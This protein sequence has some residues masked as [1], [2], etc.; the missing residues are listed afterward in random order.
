MVQ[1][2]VQIIGIGKIGGNK[3]KFGGNH[4]HKLDSSAEMF[5]A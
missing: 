3:S 4:R 2:A 5:S 1:A